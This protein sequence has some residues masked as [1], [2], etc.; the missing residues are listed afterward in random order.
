MI[1]SVSS[2]HRRRIALVLAD[3]DAQNDCSRGAVSCFADRDE[4]AVLR[5]ATDGYS[6]VSHGAMVSFLLSQTGTVR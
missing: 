4:L 1:G 2:D 6:F 3:L 5:I